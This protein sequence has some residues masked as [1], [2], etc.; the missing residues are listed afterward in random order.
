MATKEVT[1]AHKVGRAGEITLAI[2]GGVFGL[3]GG[4]FALGVGGL[5]QTGSGAAGGTDI[6]VLGWSA[7]GFSALALVAA[8]LVSSRSK[9]AGWLLLVSAI[10]GLI[11]I[12]FFYILPFILLLIAGLM[13]LLRGRKRPT[14]R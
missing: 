14:G 9:L 8:V 13:C 7:I 5:Q 1:Q 10:G 3:F 2:L 12:S 4:L 6:T 11:A